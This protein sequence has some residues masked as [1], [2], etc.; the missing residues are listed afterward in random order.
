MKRG[1][2]G[3]DYPIFRR[4]FDARTSGWGFREGEF[5]AKAPGP[6]RLV[7]KSNYCH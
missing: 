3:K 1:G 4:D 2:I 5:L 6:N 7:V